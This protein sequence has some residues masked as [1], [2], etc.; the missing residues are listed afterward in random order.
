MSKN[1]MFHEISME[2]MIFAFG[3]SVEIVHVD[4]LLYFKAVFGMMQFPRN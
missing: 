3:H 2:V 4:I 1:R